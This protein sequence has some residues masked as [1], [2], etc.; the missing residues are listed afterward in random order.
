M[1]A[2]KSMDADHGGHAVKHLLYE[3]GQQPLEALIA[4]LDELRAW[5]A[6]HVTDADWKA[7]VF[8]DALT[9]LQQAARL[10]KEALVTQPEEFAA[11]SSHWF[12]VYE[13]TFALTGTR[14][15]DQ[16][17]LPFEAQLL[18][19]QPS[20]T[21]LASIV[22]LMRG[23]TSTLQRAEGQYD[24]LMY[25]FEYAHKNTLGNLIE[26]ELPLPSEIENTVLEWAGSFSEIQ[27]G[28]QAF[29]PALL[30]IIEARLERGAEI[31]AEVIVMLRR[32][33]I[34]NSNY[35]ASGL[36]PLLKRVGG[37][38]INHGEPWADAALRDL[39]H[40]DQSAVWL[41]ILSHAFSNSSKP[42]AAWEKTATKLLETIGVNIFATHV[43]GWLE[44]VGAPRTQPLRS[45]PFA[46]GDVNQLFDPYNT[47]VARGL[48]WFAALLPP[49]DNAARI[50]ANLTLTSLK[51]VSGVGPRDPMLANAGV[52]ALGRMNSL[53]AVGQLAR[54]KTRVTFKTTL[55]EIEKALE[56]AAT[57]QGMTKADLEEL[58]IPTLGL[59][60]VGA[61][62]FQFGDVKA[63]LRVQNSDV[64]LTWSDANGKTLKNPPSSVKKDFADDLKELKTN[65]K[66]LEQMLSAQSV[67][68]ERFVLSRK[69]WVF[70][71]WSERYLEHPLVGCVA[72]RL[73]WTFAFSGDVQNGIW[74]DGQITDSSGQALEINPAATV[75]MWHPLDSSSER[76][77]DWRRFLETRG[78]VQP[79]KQAHREIYILTAAEERTD[80]Y[81]NRFAAHVLKQHQFNQLAAL[82]GWNNKLRL[83]VDDSYPPA[84]LELPQWNLRAEFWVE[85]AGDDYGVDTTEA[86]T[87]L[88]LT[89][90]QVRFYTTGS[91]INYAH[92]SGGGYTPYVH[93]DANLALP[94]RLE[95]IPA[96]VL[97]EVLRDVD[98]FV[99]VTSVG[100]DPTWNDG[101]PQGRYREYW[102]SYS[103]GEL[104][105]NAL[106]RKALLET[107]I[108]R[109]KI[110]DVTSIQGKFRHVKGSLREY[111]IHVGSGNILML[112]NDQYLCIVP[113][114]GTANTS[115]DIPLPFEGDRTLAVILSKAFMLADDKNIKDVTITRQIKG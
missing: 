18:M 32:T 23:I 73:I 4:D 39:E 54:L 27:I 89:T 110:K 20:H 61:A 115:S 67:R 62:D 13:H 10:E 81:S 9:R 43:L 65:L 37:R 71:D 49:M 99:G 111:K 25:E 83:M 16:Q 47:R 45:P 104:S 51:K 103:F 80:V 90:D 112:P 17:H 88:Y 28:N 31:P 100:N 74:C 95:T 12:E 24:A 87:Y 56:N 44:K 34:T 60:T 53:F 77:L 41:E 46:R 36:V 79:W 64:V 58:S 98:L 96:L 22:G 2:I 30:K 70:T 97:S 86:G 6:K 1:S 63:E 101:G 7:Q 76:V 40:L 69:T 106:N 55:K 57:R 109:L 113:G 94:L 59:E 114:Q 8:A 33:D 50:M 82:R 85:G 105:D 26:A 91:R 48:V 84:T 66:D 11:L 35:G 15:H 68:L 21:R 29:F 19:R 14:R 78:I 108:P 93:Q 52:F 3:L 102:Q 5:A 42:S 38:H 107:L 75:T 92:A 72:R